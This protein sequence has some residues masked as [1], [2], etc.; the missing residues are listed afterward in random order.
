MKIGILANYLTTRKDILRFCENLAEKEEVVL[1]I[2]KGEKLVAEKNARLE[3]RYYDLKPT[4]IVIRAWNLIWFYLNILFGVKPKSLNNYIITESFKFSEID[5]WL[6]RNFRMS[7]LNMT[8]YT[9]QLISYDTYLRFL[10][11][12]VAVDFTGIDCYLI[13]TEVYNDYLFYKILQQ[14]A[15]KLMYVYSWDHPCKMIRFSK[16]IDYY[17][18]WNDELRSDLHLL[19]AI[20]VDKTYVWGAT[21]FTDIYNYLKSKDLLNLVSY[22]GKYFYFVCATGKRNLV[23]AEIELIIELSKVIKSLDPSIKLVVRRYPFWKNSNVYDRL[24]K[25][26]NIQLEEDSSNGSYQ[27]YH[28]AEGA[29]ALFHIGTTLGLEIC[30][31]NTPSILLDMSGRTNVLSTFVHQYQN[32]KYLNKATFP[33]VVSSEEQLKNVVQYCISGRNA[34]DLLA[35]NKEVAGLTD[36]RS[37]EDLTEDFIS[38]TYKLVK[39]Y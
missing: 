2:R 12:D 6:Y 36:L 10:R 35:Y 39:A 23:D 3:I 13:T 26:P 18:V 32:D 16:K 19:Q 22:S 25:S 20:P 21:Q 38:I 9:P 29:M 5:N 24:S 34:D 7:L 11:R 31:F 17:L 27:K 30:Y 14:D 8:R 33:N 37:M 4:S 28:S 15:P 1:F